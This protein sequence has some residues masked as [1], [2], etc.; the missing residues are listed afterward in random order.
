MCLLSNYNYLLSN[1]KIIRHLAKL[2]VAGVSK[3][4]GK[5]YSYVCLMDLITAKL[6]TKILPYMHVYY[7]ICYTIYG[8]T[9][10]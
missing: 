6:I 7:N 2:I 4:Y 3:M 9:S 10:R 5:P 8:H 1:Q